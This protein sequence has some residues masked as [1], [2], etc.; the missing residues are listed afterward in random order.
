[1]NIGLDI[2]GV[3][4]LYP[5]ICSD[6]SLILREAGNTISIIT[7]QEWDKVKEKVDKAKVTYDHHFSIVDYHR[8]I[9]TKMWQD[10]KGR[11]WMEENIWA[12]SKGDYMLREHIDIHFDDS[13][14][15]AKYVPDFT[16]FVLVPKKNWDPFYL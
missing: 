4:S 2:H 10:E 12:R 5:E 1:M 14:E 6:F 3:I 13:L 9:G 8:E 7:G 15:Y 11:Y 16:T